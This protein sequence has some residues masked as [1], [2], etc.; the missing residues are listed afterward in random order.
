MVDLPVIVKEVGQGMGPESIR[1]L[2]NYPL[3]R[4]TSR[5]GWDQLFETGAAPGEQNRPEL[6]EP[7]AFAGHTA[8][9]MLW[10]VNDILEDEHARI[11]CK[12]VIVSEASAIFWM[13]MPG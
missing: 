6:F 9:E 1:R 11:A 5:H 4:W 8:E 10:F 3:Q 12:Q 13:A 7:L 2:R